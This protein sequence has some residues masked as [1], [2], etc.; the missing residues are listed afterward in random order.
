MTDT[1]RMENLAHTKPRAITPTTSTHHL[2]VRDQ[3]HNEAGDRQH[4]RR[5]VKEAKE[6][7]KGKASLRHGHTI[8]KVKVRL[9]MTTDK[10]KKDSTTSK[11][12]KVKDAGGDAVMAMLR[13]PPLNRNY[14][15]LTHYQMQLN[16]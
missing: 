5:A 16:Q 15:T 10:V 8:R 12:G 3:R 2:T 7:P 6:R 9:R 13:P 14:P 4:R 11:V 1:V